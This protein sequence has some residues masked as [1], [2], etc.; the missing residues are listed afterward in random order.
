[1]REIYKYQKGKDFYRNSLEY[2]EYDEDMFIKDELD[3]YFM[4]DE[5]IAHYIALKIKNDW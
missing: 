2:F 3:E 1:M 4:D 5:E